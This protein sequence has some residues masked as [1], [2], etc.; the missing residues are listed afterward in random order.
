MREYTTNDVTVSMTEEMKSFIDALV[1]TN[2]FRSRKDAVQYVLANALKDRESS[3][4][5]L[6]NI[7]EELKKLIEDA[8]A[9]KKER[10]M[11]FCDVMNFCTSYGEITKTFCLDY[12]ELIKVLTAGRDLRGAYGFDNRIVKDGMD[13][14][15][16]Y[17]NAIERQGFR[18]VLLDSFDNPKQHGV[19]TLMAVRL[20]KHAVQDDYDTAIIVTGDKD[21][22]PAI[23]EVQALGKR[24]E[25]AFL[26]AHTS[27]EMVRKADQF[28]DLSKYSLLRV[29]SVE[30]KGDLA[31]LMNNP[32]GE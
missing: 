22:Y 20:Y 9:A 1:N 16:K 2:Q 31:K 18:M 7:T 24:V 13:Q 11:I 5:D 32:D 25:V 27:A 23:A 6:S 15:A 30:D 3:P 12:A 21:F 19:D 29:D 4:V 28:V 26:P 17:H 8:I 14:T 10:V